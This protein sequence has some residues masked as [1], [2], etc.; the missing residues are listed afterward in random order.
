MVHWLNESL[1]QWIRIQARTRWPSCGHLRARE[2]DFA[3]V[4]HEQ[5]DRFEAGIVGG[6]QAALVHIFV[7]E[8]LDGVAEDF[9][10]VTRLGA[11]PS[12]P[13]G[14]DIGC[15]S[16]RRQNRNRNTCDRM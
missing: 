11:D 15:G 8:V 2:V 4:G 13:R 14:A 16:D 10:G 3:V 7:A 1:L 12:P 6:E 5:L 9:E